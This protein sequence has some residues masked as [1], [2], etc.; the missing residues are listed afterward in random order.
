MNVLFD[1]FVDGVLGHVQQTILP[2]LET[3]TQKTSDR[4]SAPRPTPSS[5]D[6]VYITDR[7]IA[8][9]QPASSQVSKYTD[10]GRDFQ[11]T[12]NQ[13]PKPVQQP[14]DVVEVVA[15]D[16]NKDINPNKQQHNTKE[17]FQEQQQDIE[18]A[19]EKM[20]DEVPVFPVENDDSH[21][22][23][24]TVRQSLVRETEEI[25]LVEESRSQQEK[26]E[27]PNM[28]TE[29]ELSQQPATDDK[30]VDSESASLEEET[31][32]NQ[33]GQIMTNEN[34]ET[35]SSSKSEIT[36]SLPQH[37]QVSTKPIVNSPATIITY[38]DKRHGTDH[39]L[40]YSLMDTPPDDR[41]LILFRRQIVQMGWWSPCIERSETPS[42]SK[43][44]KLCYAIHAYLE[45]DSSNVAMV[46]CS[47]G[48]TRTAIAMACYLKFAG[49]VQHS[50]QGFLYFLS[51]RGIAKPEA[52]WRQLP[53]S[54]HNFFRQ[55]DSA[56]EIGGFLNRKPLLLR[57]IALQGIPV[58]EKP[59]L[60]IWDSSKRHV[61]SSHPEVWNKKEGGN[62]NED[63]N[64]ELSSQ[65]GDEEGFY[66]VNVIL[67]GDFLLLCRFG[68]EFASETT[69]H[70]PSKI[71]F[72]YANTTGFLSGGCP[73]ELPSNRVDLMRQYAS[74]FDEED[75]LVT[76]LFEADWEEAQYQVNVDSR[77]IP[78]ELRARRKCLKRP[79]RSCNEKVWRSYERMSCEEGWKII[80]G[81]HSAKPDPSDI[82]NFQRMYSDDHLEQCPSNLVGLALQLTNFEYKRAKQLLCEAPPF[83]WWHQE[84]VKDSKLGVSSQ[85]EEDKK[86][87]DENESAT[88]ILNILA[89]VD[90]T[91]NLDPADVVQLDAFEKQVSIL[92]EP[93]IRNDDSSPRSVKRKTDLCLRDAGWMVP[94]MAF[95]RQGDIAARFGTQYEQMQTKVDQ[96]MP[97][98]ESD[99]LPRMPFFPHDRP[100]VIPIPS[101]RRKRGLQETE[102]IHWIPAYDERREMAREL[103]TQIN[104]TGVTLPGLVSLV[105]SSQRWKGVPEL[106]EEESD[107][108][109]GTQEIDEEQEGIR[110]SFSMENTMNREA[111]EKKENEWEEAKKV[112]EAKKR[113]EREKAEE[114]K[115]IKEG[116]APLKDDPEYSKYFK[117]LKMGMQ[118][119]QVAH[120]LTRD[121]KDLSIIDLDP[122][123]SLKS[124]WP[125]E[126]KEENGEVPLKDDPE[127]SKYFKML[128]MGMPKEQVAHALTRDE[129]DLSILEL[130]PEK[131]L[132]SQKSDERKGEKEIALK[133][134]PEY[135][136][137]FKMLSMGLPLDAVKNALLRDGKDPKVMDLDRNK[138]IKSQQ[139]GT[140]EETDLPSLKDDPDY[141]KYF[142]MLSM[143]LPVDAV[144]NALVRDSK[145]PTIMD[146][147][148]NKSLKSQLGQNEEKDLGIPIKDDPE[149]KKYFKMLGMGLPIDAVKNAL[150]RDGKDPN[151]MDLD[152]NKSLAFQSKTM[153]TD[154]ISLKPSKKKKKIRRKKIYW[155][156]I[157]SEKLKPD[158]MWHIVKDA[159]DIN[160]L[161][162]DEEEF[163]ELFTESA[164]QGGKKKVSPEKAKKKLV[165]VIDTKRSMNGAIILKRL[166][167]DYEVISKY[168][169][170]M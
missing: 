82:K 52:T 22:E 74:H 81:N 57:A 50:Y 161:S 73:H 149:Y 130:D 21:G 43:L 145:D 41:T 12:S 5:T 163:Q 139:K 148:P 157:Q 23:T 165:Q 66:K 60:D 98:F 131:S 132:K 99:V 84:L 120:A 30:L 34:D 64:N 56:L 65:W 53:P 77:E 86:L 105:E 150:S 96:S 164:D 168:V 162:Y 101:K 19:P 55:F 94:S 124:Q 169:T 9:S 14:L 146:L 102:S 3:F 159:I 33:V 143:G 106:L 80:Y 109:A 103:L 170:K 114:T 134:D 142:K 119:E 144:K 123:K 89:Q 26:S 42:I 88:Q 51:K 69:I 166:K 140:K 25:P 151:I 118:K 115:R 2:T 76:L 31:T 136:K 44:I 38:L 39:Y 153:K 127:F 37:A 156:T 90:V 116:G 17:N 152:P 113:E 107:M 29:S 62:T 20:E 63:E 10:K 40:A 54:L 18:P 155:N 36:T 125:T 112:E 133:D 87:V 167:I 141:A 28:D 68:G 72:R 67:E 110:L 46:Y 137:Y 135:L 47:N 121:G 91:K 129:K 126:T 128:K 117:M 58:D 48:K 95:P 100:S 11:E 75:F 92:Q 78:A 32:T 158:S 108:K 147:D 16:D 70:D 138:S 97:T 122:N 154:S 93:R 13:P 27:A 59:C 83:A 49:M 15:E 104:H 1:D 111:K 6:M 35:D 7:L 160:K 4:L 61:Y 45:L 8:L 79:S 85:S 71:L 24:D